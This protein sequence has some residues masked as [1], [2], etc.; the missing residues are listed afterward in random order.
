[1]SERI[2]LNDTLQSAIVKLA[3]GNPGAI[4]AMCEVTKSSDAVDPQ[5]ALG[6]FSALFHLDSW[7]IYGPNIWLLWKDVCGQSAINFLALLRAAQLGII[8]QR[9]VIDAARTGSITLDLGDVLKKVQAQ[10]SGFAKC[11]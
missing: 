3:E 6:A 5:S 11:V 9:V 7:G 1:M 10:L 8:S 2:Q 4:A